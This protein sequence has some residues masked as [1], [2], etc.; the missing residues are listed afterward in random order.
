MAKK[1]MA[2]D[3]MNDDKAPKKRGRP[4]MK[5]DEGTTTTATRTRTKRSKALIGKIALP[6]DPR[7]A[8]QMGVVVG[9]ACGAV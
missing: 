8:F 7:A 3:F 5:N 6:S 4:P 1:E 2:A 9:Q